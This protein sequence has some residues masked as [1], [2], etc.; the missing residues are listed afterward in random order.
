MPSTDL[1]IS[2]GFCG[3]LGNDIA[4]LPELEDLEAP[5]L[6]KPDQLEVHERELWLFPSLRFSCRGYIIAWRLAAPPL[7]NG[8]ARPELSVWREETGIENRY[9]KTSASY[10]TRNP[11]ENYSVGDFDIVI[12]TGSFSEPYVSF[13]PGD[14]L[15]LLLR[16]M[17]VVSFVPYLRAVSIAQDHDPLGYYLG[18][19]GS[20]END[21][22]ILREEMAGDVLPLMSLKLC[23][24]A[25][26]VA[27]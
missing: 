1:L 25:F 10:L 8:G 27:T 21:S 5:I 17:Q 14:I 9:L 20:P 26:T 11:A 6:E 22:I 23:S 18:R 19:A 3:C 7:S 4:A 2:A 24:C 16:R 15:G 12:H 13:Q